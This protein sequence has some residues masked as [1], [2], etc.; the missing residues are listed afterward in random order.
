MKA[1]IYKAMSSRA[2]AMLKEDME[3]LGPV[4]SR[5]VSAAQ[6]ELLSLANKL[7]AEGRIVLRL[8]TDNDLSV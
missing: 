3:A 5:D 6:Q 7:E 8:E 4:R 2:A 1:H